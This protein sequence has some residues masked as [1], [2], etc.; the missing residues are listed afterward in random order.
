MGCG[1]QVIL[2]VA[3]SGN[4]NAGQ[5]FGVAAATALR[6][7]HESS[8]RRSVTATMTSGSPQRATS[9]RP[10]TA[11]RRTCQSSSGG[12]FGGSST[13]SPGSSGAGAGSS[14]EFSC[15]SS[16]MR[17]GGRGS[18]R[19]AMK[20][21][22]AGRLPSAPAFG[23]ASASS[24]A[25]ARRSSGTSSSM[26]RKIFKANAGSPSL[27][28][29]RFKAYMTARRTSLSLWLNRR[30]SS[31]I[32][33]G[34]ALFV[35]RRKD[36]TATIL[37]TESESSNCSQSALMDN[38]PPFLPS[39]PMALVAS[40]RTSPRQHFMCAR[41][42]LQTTLLPRSAKKISDSHA[43]FLMQASASMSPVQSN[44]RARSSF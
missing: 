19:R 29:N 6:T 22:N 33:K 14:S 4:P 32:T 20:A 26:W 34:S 15:S 23:E 43:A 42:A 18:P 28:Q 17:S 41:A 7:S 35:S 37:T 2:I 25:A 12:G 16:S 30:R 27:L 8:S 24:S 36:S 13:G 31:D 44:V 39:W 9:Q 10:A 11:S 3:P 38:S 5:I 1:W 40:R 21:R